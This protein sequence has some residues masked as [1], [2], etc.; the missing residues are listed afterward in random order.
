M[1]R[2]EQE[3][4]KNWTPR[5]SEDLSNKFRGSIQNI[6]YLPTE[7]GLILGGGLP[8]KRENEMKIGNELWGREKSPSEI[9]MIQRKTE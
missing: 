6:L 1:L 2:S 4:S 3:Q 7:H 9:Q 5:D 8:R